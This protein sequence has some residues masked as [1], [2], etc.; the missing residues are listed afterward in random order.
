[1]IKKINDIR[2]KYA[3]VKVQFRWVDYE[4]IRGVF[5][6]FRGESANDYF[7]R[8]AEKLTKMHMEGEI[9]YALIVMKK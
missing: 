8:L 5:P 9:W 7:K 6:A 4:K 2:Y 1:M 3:M